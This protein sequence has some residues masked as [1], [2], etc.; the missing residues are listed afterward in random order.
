MKEKNAKVI[1]IK[2]LTKKG[3][4]ALLLAEK[5]IFTLFLSPDCQKLLS[6]SRTLQHVT[7][8]TC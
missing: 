5:H 4:C 7:S 6:P 2:A 3:F 8:I 1:M